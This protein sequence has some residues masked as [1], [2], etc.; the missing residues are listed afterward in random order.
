MPA[1]LSTIGNA[2]LIKLGRIAEEFQ[3]GKHLEYTYAG[4]P[5]IA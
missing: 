1:R 4:I 3:R 2:H 5:S